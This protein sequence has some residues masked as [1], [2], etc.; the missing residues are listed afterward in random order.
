M[1]R[2]MHRVRLAANVLH[3]V[4]L[5]A[6]W[7]ANGVDVGA[8]HPERRPEALSA[9]DANASLEATVGR[10]KSAFGDQ[11]RRGVSTC[12]VPAAVGR[13]VRLGPRRDD[14]AASSVERGVR[15]AGRIILPLLVAPALT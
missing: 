3:H 8:E 1:N 13:I 2:S 10:L 6:P 4:D 15:G 11:P 9:R 14:E 7:P 12:P 5:A